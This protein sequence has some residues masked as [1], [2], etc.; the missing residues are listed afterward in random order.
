M[1]KQINRDKKGNV[2]SFSLC[3]DFGINGSSLNPICGYCKERNLE[4]YQIC[5]IKTYHKKDK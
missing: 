2:I 3:E 5:I 4:V 1:I